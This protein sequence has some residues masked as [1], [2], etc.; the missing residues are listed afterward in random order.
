ME[1]LL[2]RFGYVK[3]NRYGLVLTPEGRILSMRHAVLDDGFGG[4]IVGWMDTDLVATQLNQWEARKQQIMTQAALAPT[5]PVMPMMAAR[6]VAPPP[7]PVA[8]EAEAPE[9]DWEWTIAIARARAEAETSIE[10]Q[11]PSAPLL[12]GV[13]P[14]ASARSS[15]PSLA[16]APARTVPQ[17]VTGSV[18][19]LSQQQAPMRV[20]SPPPT[21]ARRPNATMPPPLPP[22]EKPAPVTKPVLVAKPAPITR[23]I[24]VTPPAAPR[25]ERYDAVR[26]ESPSAPMAAVTPIVATKKPSQPKIAPVIPIR[27]LRTPTAPPPSFA[28]AA[29]PVTVIPVPKIP[30][31][32]KGTHQVIPTP[33]LDESTQ[34]GLDIR[35]IGESTRVD[36]PRVAR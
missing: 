17:V 21:P 24:A 19:S 33:E 31:V 7:F 25:T 18:P 32:A 2:A 4:R 11:R 35:E 3:L 12:A 10:P 6:P 20:A 29:S 36:L 26:P 23:P 15:V 1:R 5:V 16:K 27:P 22:V 28:R 30:R 13:R 9:D 34:V 8:H 14:L